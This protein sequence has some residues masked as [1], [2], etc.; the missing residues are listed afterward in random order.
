MKLISHRG[1]IDGPNYKLEN[2][3][4][5]IEKTL[6][7]GY[8]VEVDVRFYKNNFYLGHDEPQFKVSKKFLKN[9]KIWCHA[10]D[11]FALEELKK[12]NSIF[13]W[14]QKDDYTITSNGFFWTYPGRKILVDSIYV[15][16]KKKKVN[17]N[18]AGICSDY[19]KF[20]KKF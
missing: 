20:Y 13:F 1:N 11:Y 2:N 17:F 8:E 9:K 4:I 15:L 6:N 3:P 18:C 7:E 16:Q 10:K 12:N 19:V 14:H 5:Y